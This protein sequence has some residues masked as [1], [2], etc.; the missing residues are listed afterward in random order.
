MYQVP[1][2]SVQETEHQKRGEVRSHHAVLSCKTFL[3]TSVYSGVTQRKRGSDW[4]WRWGHWL[5]IGQTGSVD[6]DLPGNATNVTWQK[7]EGTISKSFFKKFS[8]LSFN[9]NKL[10]L[11]GVTNTRSNSLKLGRKLGKSGKLKKGAWVGL[12]SGVGHY[13]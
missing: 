6:D 1:Q 5:R 10:A 2:S 12:F 8:C 9:T 7:C 4:P 11:L 3:R 13:Y